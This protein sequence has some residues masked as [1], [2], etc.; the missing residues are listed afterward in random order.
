MLL[1]PV[2]AGHWTPS[3]G[4]NFVVNTTDDVD[5]GACNTAHCSLREAIAAANQRPGPDRIVFGLPAGSPFYISLSSP[6]PP[7]SD[8]AT[9]L[10]GSTQP[11]VGPDG[12][13]IDGSALPAEAS[14]LV[15]RAADCAVF[16]LQIRGFADAGIVVSG[17][18]GARI[19]A[20]QPRQGNILAANDTGIRIEDGASGTVIEG[21]FVGLLPNGAADGNRTG[22]ALDGLTAEVQNIRI[23]GPAPATGNIISGNE[24]S[25]IFGRNAAGVSLFSNRIGTDWSGLEAVP[26]QLS[27]IDCNDCRDIIIGQAPF[28]G[29]VIG[30]NGEHGILL[31]RFRSDRPVN[32]V[33]VG[34]RIGSDRSGEAA[35]SNRQSGIYLDSVAGVQIGGE[36][37]GN[38]ISGNRANGIA[39]TEV[40]D[41]TI[42]GNTIGVNGSATLTLAN[43]LD[44]IAL[45]NGR[46]IAITGNLVAGNRADGI[47]LLTCTQSVLTA[48]LIGLNAR[49]QALPNFRAG[50]RLAGCRSIQAGTPMAGEGN[51]VAFN[52]EGIVLEDGSSACSVRGNS[53]YCNAGGLLI[54]AGSNADMPAPKDLCVTLIEVT[55]AAAPGATVDLYRHDPDVCPD[56]PCQGRTYLGSAQ[57]GADSLWIFPVDLPADALVTA[58]ATDEQGNTSP[59]AVCTPVTERPLAQAANGGEVCPGAPFTL[60]GEG[61]GAGPLRYDWRGPEGY[62]STQQNPG[63]ALTPGWYYLY[64]WQDGCASVPDST[65]ARNLGPVEIVI[66][67]E[68]SEWICPGDSVVVNGTVYNLSRPRGTELITGPGPACDTLVIIDLKI[69]EAIPGRVEL[70]LCPGES[71][72]VGAETFD[73][74]RPSG[75]VVLPGAA[76][77]GCDSLVEVDLHFVRL[78]AEMASRGVSCAGETDGSIVLFNVS[79]GAPP[80]RLAFNGGGPETILTFPRRFDNLVAG[81]YDLELED[82]DGCRRLFTASVAP[83][84]RRILQV[85][86]DVQLDFGDSLQLQPTL[87]FLPDSVRWAPA[88]G[89]SCADCLTPTARPGQ[90]TTYTLTAR[91]PEGCRLSTSIT[92][93][94]NADRLLYLPNAFSPN[95]DGINDRFMVFGNGKAVKTIRSLRIFDRWGNLLYEAGDFPP[96][97]DAAAWDGQK[98]GR[99][100]PA[101][102]YP[103]IVEG[104]LADDSIRQWSGAVTLLR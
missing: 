76:R 63:D 56:S 2:F 13:V 88:S 89:L 48:N 7:L 15:L 79:G 73:E 70:T 82:A 33:I 99:P 4:Q 65:E 69:R 23:G 85:G 22:I 66:G 54:N 9:V 101:G 59:F 1:L 21:N 16:G 24:G 25:G 18:S 91:T 43:G 58:T 26:N 61:Q 98:Q 42:A 19:G 3:Y 45:D 81:E 52:R 6:L 29:N 37:A 51:T 10:D 96:G 38:L 32:A 36:N 68:P 5:D 92:V 84:V 47:A 17:A 44:G 12:V 94:V 55:G 72:I 90:T 87:N 77:S 86:A 34:N 100:L 57:A 41:I 64:V 60:T 30:G 97:D 53:L 103:Y 50:I 62:R 78:E 75:R 67:D 102:V 11:G 27:G 104:V 20:G 35:I 71:L 40:D 8:A 14:G 31:R 95:D 83:P 74:Q 49:G 39:G 46:N 80:Y 93:A 28:S